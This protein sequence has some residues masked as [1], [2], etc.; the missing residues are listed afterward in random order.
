MKKTLLFIAAALFSTALIAQDLSS[1][2]GIFRFDDETTLESLFA[3]ELDDASASGEYAAFC[4]GV[5][6]RPAGA[7]GS[8]YNPEASVLDTDFSIVDGVDGKAIRVETGSFL[9]LWHGLSLDSIKQYFSTSDGSPKDPVYVGEG[10]NNYT[11]M[12]DV[13]FPDLTKVYTLYEVNPFTTSGGKSG[14]VVI[15]DAKLGADY[16]PFSGQYSTAMV[17][18]D[19]WHRIAYVADVFFEADSSVGSVKMYLDGVMVNEVAYG[20]VDGS[21]SPYAAMADG[22]GTIRLHLKLAGIT[23]VMVLII[24]MILIT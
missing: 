2:T 17:E 7:E 15:T 24:N 23:K 20:S 8:D 18:A 4:D 14:E 19:K 9:Y 10:V 21:S 11:V 5:M 1:A 13:K 22:S 6:K 3:N 16:S 12:M